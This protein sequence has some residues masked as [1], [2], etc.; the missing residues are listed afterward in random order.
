MKEQLAQLQVTGA[1]TPGGVEVVSPASPPIS[2]SS[3][4][5]LRDGEIALVLG[6]LLGLGAAFAAEYFDDKVYTKDEAERL[7]GGVPVLADHPPGEEA[8]RDPSARCSSPR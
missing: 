6:L 8:G 7:S 3:P 2:P 4:K 1:E 5:Q